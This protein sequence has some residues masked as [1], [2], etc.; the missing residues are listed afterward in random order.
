MTSIAKSN[1]KHRCYCNNSSSLIILIQ[2]IFWDRFSTKYKISRN[3]TV[4]DRNQAEQR[5][6]GGSGPQFI[7]RI[8]SSSQLFSSWPTITWFWSTR[9]VPCNRFLLFYNHSIWTDG[10]LIKTS[11]IEEILISN[12]KHMN[13]SNSTSQIQMDILTEIW[14][15]IIWYSIKNVPNK[16]L[17]IF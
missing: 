13:S 10:L 11:S 12:K 6:T 14:G 16:K 4:L 2:D 9:L 8:S 7:T 5:G 17:Q 15:L 3:F 1:F